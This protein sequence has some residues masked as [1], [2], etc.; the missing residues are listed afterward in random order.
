MKDQQLPFTDVMTGEEKKKKSDNLYFLNE[1]DLNKE[2][3]ICPSMLI[4]NAF[5]APIIDFLY[6]CISFTVARN[7]CF[8]LPKGKKRL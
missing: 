5:I 1:I 4:R 8:P 3:I 7:E 2:R 6:T